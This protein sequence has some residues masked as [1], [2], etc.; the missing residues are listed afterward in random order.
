MLVPAP[1]TPHAESGWLFLGWGDLAFR[2]AAGIAHFCVPAD[3]LTLL[4]LGRVLPE[5]VLSG[6]VGRVLAGVVALPFATG[7]RCRVAATHASPWRVRL[8]LTAPALEGVDLSAID[9]PDRQHPAYD[10]DGR[11]G[12][13]ARR[14]GA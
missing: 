13:L 2:D 8:A 1:P 12:P 10:E 9:V 5:T 14:H 11:K 4:L 6:L 7:G 3:G